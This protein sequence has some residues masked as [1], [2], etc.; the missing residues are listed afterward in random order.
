MEGEPAS[1]EGNRPLTDRERRLAHWMLENGDPVGRDF[2]P[3]LA[4]AAV[5]AWRCPCGCASF[6]FQIEG[7]SPARKGMN[8]LGDFVFGDEEMPSGIFIFAVDGV[9]S[10]IEVYEMGGGISTSLPEPESLRPW[11]ISAND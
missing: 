9:L 2:I 5:T 1:T 7:R 10:G 6:N 11:G 3:Q 4:Q 8:V